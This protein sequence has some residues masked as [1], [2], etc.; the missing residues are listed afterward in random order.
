[1]VVTKS[2]KGYRNILGGLNPLLC[3]SGIMALLTLKRVS[4]T[5]KPVRLPG[6]YCKNNALPG[7]DVGSIPTDCIK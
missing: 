5:K 6:N 7:V 1:M 3:N 2:A 4:L